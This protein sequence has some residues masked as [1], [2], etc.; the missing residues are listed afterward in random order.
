MP[1]DQDVMQL[2]EVERAYDNI[3]TTGGFG[4]RFGV[5]SFNIH[6]N[7]HVHLS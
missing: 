5:G 7:E 1:A 2:A 4:G 6:W 3:L